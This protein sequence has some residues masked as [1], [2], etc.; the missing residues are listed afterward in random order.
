MGLGGGSFRGGSNTMPRQA[1]ASYTLSVRQLVKAR[2]GKKAPRARSL[3]CCSQPGLVYEVPAAT[4]ANVG[5]EHRAV[6]E[7][8]PAL[9]NVYRYSRM[10]TEFR[11]PSPLFA[12]RQGRLDWFEA[13]RCGGESGPRRREALLGCFCIERRRFP[14]GA[15]SAEGA[16]IEFEHP[17]GSDEA[18][19]FKDPRIQGCCYF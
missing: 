19:S 6:D 13:R 15:V 11:M 14:D 2:D 16:W 17:R 12:R 10:V 18:P 5:E 9:I 8:R 4:K 1:F 3:D 7:H